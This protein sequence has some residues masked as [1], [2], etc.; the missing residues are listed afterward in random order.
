MKTADGK[1]LWLGGEYHEVVSPERLVFTHE[2]DS[3]KGKPGAESLV[4]VVLADIDGKTQMTF[5]QTG[6]TSVESLDGHKGGWTE[7]FNILEELLA[8][9]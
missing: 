7:C 5:R 6:F 1:E 9:E 4:T 2:W 3:D 8:T